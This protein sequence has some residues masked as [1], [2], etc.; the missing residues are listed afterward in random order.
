MR[1]VVCLVFLASF[2]LVC[3]GEAYRG[4]YTGPIPRPP[5]Y[6]RPP[7]GPVCNHCYRLA[8]PDARNCCSRFGRCC[9]LVK[10]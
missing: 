9:H 2:A 3:Q 5:P 6:G 1:L 7:L 10:G 8:F 4:G